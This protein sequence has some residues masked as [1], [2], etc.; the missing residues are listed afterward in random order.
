M[1]YE[2]MPETLYLKVEAE[3]WLSICREW[4]GRHDAAQ[5]ATFDFVK[6]QGSAGL[7]P[8]LYGDLIGI[9]IQGSVPTGWSIKKGR[10]VA[11]HDGLAQR[12]ERFPGICATPRSRKQSDIPARSGM[13]AK[14]ATGAVG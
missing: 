7:F 1:N 12:S 5:C 10:R 3:P 6:K 4:K 8:D 14:T 2:S 9:A 11:Q 13:T